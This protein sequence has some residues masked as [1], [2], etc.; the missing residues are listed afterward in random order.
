MQLQ[1][2]GTAPE[3]G[4]SCCFDTKCLTTQR[5]FIEV[6]REYLLLG[7]RIFYAIGKD[8]LFNLARVAIFIGQQQV[9]RNLL[10]DRLGTTRPAAAEDIV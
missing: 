10:G 1:L 4:L 9:F 5:D 7:Q 3:I 6:K 8:R 2:I